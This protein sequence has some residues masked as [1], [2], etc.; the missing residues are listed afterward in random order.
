M[1]KLRHVIHVSFA[2]SLVGAALSFVLGHEFARDTEVSRRDSGRHGEHD[3]ERE[4]G[5]GFS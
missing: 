2:L 3:N 5:V 4:E 1:G